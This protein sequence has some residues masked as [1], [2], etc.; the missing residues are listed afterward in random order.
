MQNSEHTFH[1]PVMGLGYTIDSPLKVARFGIS[2]VISIIEDDLVEQMREYHCKN[3]GIPYQKIEKEDIDFRSKRICSYLN[4]INSM[5]NKQLEKLKKEDFVEGNEIVKYFEL[6][7][8]VSNLRKE[9]FLMLEENDPFEKINKQNELREKIVAGKIDVNIMTKCDRTNYDADGNELQKE[10]SDAMSALRGFALSDLN[11]SVVFSAG[12]NPRLYT[13]CENFEDFTKIEEGSF[14]KR[15]I[16]KVSDYRSAMIQGKFLAKK[17]LWVSEFR[18]ESGLNCGGHA[19]PTNG[20]LL[21]P[22]LEEFKLNKI[23]LK[24]ILFEMFNVAIKEKSS[25]NLQFDSTIRISVQGGIGTSFENEFLMNYYDIDYTGW[26][27]PFLLVPEA[28]NVDEQTLQALVNAKKEDYYLSLASPLGIPFNN[29]RVTSSQEQK[30]QRIDSNKPGSP[31]YKKFLSFNTE[32]TSKAICLASKSYQKHKLK[33]LESVDMSDDLRKIVKAE[34][35]EKEC[36]C[37][38]LVNSVL[39]KND[40]KPLY[41][42]TAVSI[43]P[44]PNLAYFSNTFSLRQMVNHIYGRINILNNLNRPNLFV[45]ELIMYSD[46]LKIELKKYLLESTQNKRKYL[47][48]FKTNLLSGIEYYVQL[49]PNMKLTTKLEESSFLDALNFHKMELSKIEL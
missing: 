22:I 27:S 10:Y 29:F 46:Y 3:E 49:I 19:F 37:E 17:G 20:L 2:S 30:K 47:Q 43:C 6:L 44:G 9:Y 48:E 26:G 21:G 32:F 15:I 11:A 41:N 33:E 35:L 31:C 34:L 40:I 14:K 24:N 7:P 38:G 36:L 42:I 25:K 13:Y 39:I 18:I 12:M 1:I 28:T 45:N 5:V 23:E 4:L 8:D 16:L